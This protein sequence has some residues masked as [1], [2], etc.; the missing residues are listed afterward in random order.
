MSQALWVGPATR[1]NPDRSILPN[2]TESPDSR[3]LLGPLWSPS[4][5]TISGAC[6][7]FAG[8]C[9][10]SG[11]IA[12]SGADW[13]TI[14]TSAGVARCSDRRNL[15]VGEEAVLFKRETAA[16]RRAVRKRQEGGQSNG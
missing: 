9:W 1:G 13:V 7:V 6:R 4:G 5:I 10:R 16:F 8:D 15:L 2:L 12:A 14:R 11:T 3:R